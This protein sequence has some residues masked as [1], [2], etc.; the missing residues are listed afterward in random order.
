MCPLQI[1]ANKVAQV[2]RKRAVFTFRFFQRQSVQL[3]RHPESDEGRAF[4]FFVVFHVLV[5]FQNVHTLQSKI[6]NG[7]FPYHQKKV[8]FFLTPA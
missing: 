6:F 5:Y 4:V 1:P 8:I 2:F 7:V 3:V